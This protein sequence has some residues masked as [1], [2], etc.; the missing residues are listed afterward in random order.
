MCRWRGA[1]RVQMD[2]LVGGHPR[3]HD[4]GGLFDEEGNQETPFLVA[5]DKGHP[6]FHPP[7]PVFVEAVI[8]REWEHCSESASWPRQAGSRQASGEARRTSEL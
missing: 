8:H 2:L 7:R 6:Q 1:C 3:L 4:I 5:V